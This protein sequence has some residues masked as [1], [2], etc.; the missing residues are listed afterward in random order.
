MNNGERE[1]L[2]GIVVVPQSSEKLLNQRQLEDYRNHRR[3]LI[4]W[5]LNL[6]KEPETAEG[7]AFDTARQ[8]SY[9]IDQFHRWIWTEAEGEYT[10]NATPGHAD[11]C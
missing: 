1:K 4:R 8:R 2:D 5:M 7:Y 6:G 10:L 3:D 9:K 11:Q